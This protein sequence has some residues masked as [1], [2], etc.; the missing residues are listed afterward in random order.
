M[1]HLISWWHWAVVATALA[2]AGCAG[3]ALSSPDPGALPAPASRPAQEDYRVQPGDT[4]AL[5]FYYHPDHDLEVVVREDG[6][7]LL[8]LVGEMQA[9]GLTP[10]LLADQ[11]AERYSA[12]LR[13]PKVSVAIKASAQ[14]GVYVGGE[15][16]KP[17]VIPYRKGLTAVQAIVEAG[18]LKDTA[19]ADQ[20]VFLQ[21]NREDQYQASKVDLTKVLESGQKD[22]DLPLG[23]SDVIYVPKSTI[24]KMNQFVQ[25][26]IIN[27]LPI[28]PGISF[29]PGL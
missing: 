28:R 26:Y 17:G 10:T 15:V 2:A 12:N 3:T 9:A 29:I 16:T 21:R 22:A 27:L 18:G 13:N 25:Q 8:P 1:R 7:L 19:R 11:I 5:K 4:L 6:K 14:K 24:A 20:V 23:P